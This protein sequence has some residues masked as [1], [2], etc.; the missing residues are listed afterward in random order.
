MIPALWIAKTG[1][2]AQQIN[3]NVIANNL[4][5][6]NTNGFKRSK[7]IFEDLI[8]HTVQQPGSKSSEET[9]SPSGFQLGT[10][11]RPIT[12][13]R[14]H[15]QGN[16]SKT[17]SL[18]DVAINGNGFFQVQLP[19][20]NA[21]YTRDGSFQ[22]NPN[23][24]LVTNNGFLIQPV[25]NFPANGNNM[26]VSRDGIITVRIPEQTQPIRVG[27]LYLANFV[28]D[29]G[30]SNIGENL[31]QE[32]EASGNPSISSPGSHG[33]GLLY[34]S[35]VETSNV[36]IAEELVNMIQAQR[37]YEI[38]SKVITTADQMLQKLSLL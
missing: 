37:A 5:N 25:I 28:N 14:E 1:L 31:Y 21:A 33:T 2:D 19:D 3:M 38:N 9:I 32:T 22:I 10:G 36:N 24:Q 16:L 17:N 18:K 13:E 34:Q 7:A 12:T 8:Y 11:V 20:G 15:S 23:G 6:V 30:L 29:S 27:K 4:A 35:Y 26:S